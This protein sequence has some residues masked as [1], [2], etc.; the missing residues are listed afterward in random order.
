MEV[1]FNQLLSHDLNQIY[2]E[3]KF[4]SDYPY[5]AADLVFLKTYRDLTTLVEIVEFKAL[6]DQLNNSFIT[7]TWICDDQVKAVFLDSYN[8]FQGTYTQ[9]KALW[10]IYQSPQII[11]NKTSQLQ[12][13][14]LVKTTIE[15]QLGALNYHFQEFYLTLKSSGEGKELLKLL[16][17][18]FP[19]L[20]K[21]SQDLETLINLMYQFNQNQSIFVN[22][23]FRSK[24]KVNQFR[25]FKLA[26]KKVFYSFEPLIKVYN[27]WISLGSLTFDGPELIDLNN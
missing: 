23:E 11:L 17:T 25:E 12:F 4:H 27:H 13:Q 15:T 22:Q 24:I 1:N 18:I 5:Q 21:T 26:L 14:K 16:T 8:H 3:V 6:F 9:L 7:G 2:K 10:K 20:M 19:E